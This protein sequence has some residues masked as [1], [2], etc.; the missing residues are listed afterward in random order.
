DEERVV[1]AA[2][3]E[4]HRTCRTERA[5]LDRVL[6]AEAEV[7]AV[8]EIRA[9]RLRQERHRHD[10]VGEPVRAQQLEDVLHARLADDAPHRLRLVRR[11]RTEPSPL[12][13]RHDD[14]FHANASRRALRAYSASATRP[15]ATPL[16]KIQSGQSVPL[17]VTMTNARLA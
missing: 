13:A 8:A 2:G 3:G 12:A 14:R 5:L 1:E 15:T 9:D 11:Q 17:R 4:A 16:Q 7:L 6:D 10:D